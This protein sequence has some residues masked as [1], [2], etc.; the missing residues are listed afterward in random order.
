[1]ASR[2]RG[3]GRGRGRFGGGFGYAKQEPFVLFPEIELP[4]AKAVKVEKFLVLQNS[5]LQRFWRSSPYYLEETVLK[6]GQNMDIERYSDRKKPKTTWERD[7]LDQILQFGCQNFPKE[8][9]GGLNVVRR[10]KKVRWN[11]SADPLDVL[12]QKEREDNENPKSKL[13]GQGEKENEEEEEEEDE[14]V[15]DDGEYSD[16]GDYEQNIDFDDDEDDFN[17]VDDGD[18][19]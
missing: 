17:M 15:E 11:Q 4:D 7:S 10:R 6:K 5:R 1:M 16:D 13:E 2:G 8:L 3:R 14:A 18:G 12:E 9:E 19:M